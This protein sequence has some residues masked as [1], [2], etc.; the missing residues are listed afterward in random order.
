M[1]DIW[2]YSNGEI[3]KINLP[4]DA[5][6]LDQSS[7][8]L[9]DGVYTTLR[10]YSRHYV[11]QFEDHVDRLVKSAQISGFE[12]KVSTEDIRRLLRIAINNLPTYHETRLRITIPKTE[13]NAIYLSAT[14]FTP[15]LQQDYLLGVHA[16]TIQLSRSDPLSKKT[17]FIKLSQAARNQLG[18]EIHELIMVNGEGYLLEGLSSNF[19]GVKEKSIFTAGKDVLPGITQRIIFKEAARL[20][21]PL[22]QFPIHISEISTLSEAFITS[23]GRAVLPV[24]S[25]DNI[26][27]GN[28]KPGNITNILLSSYQ[29]RVST[30]LIDLFAPS[31]GGKNIVVS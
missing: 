23:S 1:V 6:T 25:I 14:Q 15:P 9:P 13:P 7:L 12:I 2:K 19:Y 16:G 27:I 31:L 26:I 22:H 8:Y 4:V 18:N 10:T 3:Q 17:E 28:G 21:I 11:F 30:D 20:K 24:V 29:K 5:K